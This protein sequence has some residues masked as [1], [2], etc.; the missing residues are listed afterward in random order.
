MFNLIKTIL[1]LLNINNKE[2]IE[3]EKSKK[4]NIKYI[5]INENMILNG[6]KYEIG[7]RYYNEIEFKNNI[8]DFDWD[9][10]SNIKNYKI[11]KIKIFDDEIFTTKNFKIIEEIN[12]KQ[13]KNSKR[14][15]YQL[16]SIVKNH[17]KKVINK[18]IKTN[19]RIKLE[20][21]INSGVHKYLDKIININDDLYINKILFKYGRNKDI[22]QFINSKSINILSNIIRHNRPKDL[23]TLAKRKSRNIKFYISIEGKRK[24]DIYEFINKKDNELED[25]MDIIQFTQ[26]DL[27][28]DYYINSENNTILEYI[29][30]I[31]RKKDLDKLI[32]SKSFF[33]L[34]EIIEA[35]FDEHLD[36]L[37]RKIKDKFLLQEIIKYKGQGDAE[38]IQERK[39]KEGLTAVNDIL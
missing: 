11:I 7:K 20:A 32:Y 19:N 22:D 28:L 15:E 14:L 5:Y 4:T 23:D 30:R 1:N 16:I 12:Y 13:F 18:F 36:I 8:D 35:G 39:R 9:L 31:G 24:K 25:I 37:V 2:K 3:E 17:E 27:C 38:I 34:R 10:L 26:N 33:I 6:V 29:A 21:V